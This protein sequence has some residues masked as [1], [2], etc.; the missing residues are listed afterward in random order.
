MNAASMPQ[1]FDPAA[2]QGNLANR[3]IVSE[4]TQ[5]GALR[6][7]TAID[8]LPVQRSAPTPD[9][10][11][12][13]AHLLRLVPG[14]HQADPAIRRPTPWRR[15]ETRATDDVGACTR[16]LHL[17]CIPLHA[18]HV[19]EGVVAAS[20]P[21][22]TPCCKTHHRRLAGAKYGSRPDDQ[23]TVHAGRWIGSSRLI[24]AG[25]CCAVPK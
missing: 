15:A 4:L 19:T 23:M 10:P 16:L 3:W 12:Y 13:L 1:G 25:A 5:V 9:L 2:C 24:T 18:V 20:S 6:F 11:V 7:R 22:A 8:E 17:I 21:R 14:V